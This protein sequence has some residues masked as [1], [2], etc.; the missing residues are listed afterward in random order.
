[1]KSVQV[2]IDGPSGAGK[3]TIAKELSKKL[4]FVYIDTGAMYRA[5]GLYV[6]NKGISI[7]DEAGVVAVLDEI[8]IDIYYKDELQH[9]NLCGEDVTHLIRTPEIS[10]AASKVSSYM[11]VREKLVDMQR[12]LGEKYSVIMDGRDIGTCVLPDA[13]VKI[14]LTADVKVRA[15]RRYD[16]LIEK[17]QDVTYEFVLSDMEKRDYDDSHREHSP[18]RRADDAIELDTADLTL[19]ES[20]AAVRQIISE[21]TGL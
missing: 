16:E 3:S 15:Q 2:A 20:I 4:G 11:K 18:L 1:M 8:D 7:H 21:R 17:G 10:M 9:I 6:V 19:E 5:V 13:N 12:K 14:F